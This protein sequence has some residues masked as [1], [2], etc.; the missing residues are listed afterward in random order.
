M[1]RQGY[2]IMRHRTVD[3]WAG[4]FERMVNGI[5]GASKPETVI[6]AA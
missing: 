1:G 2:E 6:A 3:W 5:V 4:E